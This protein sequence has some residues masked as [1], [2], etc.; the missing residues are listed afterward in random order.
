MTDSPMSDR[1]R[2][3]RCHHREYDTGEL[4]AAGGFWSKIFDIQARKFTTV[5]CRRC[6]RTELFQ[7][8]R[9]TTLANV[10]DLFT[11]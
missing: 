8:D 7:V 11:T 5:T 9:H 4:H 2:C 1:Y 6:H 10:F 3:P